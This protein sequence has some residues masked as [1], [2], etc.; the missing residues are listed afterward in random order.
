MSPTM[1]MVLSCIGVFIG[2]TGGYWQLHDNPGV[3]V[4]TPTF[5]IGFVMAGFVPLGSY[6]VGLISKAP[7]EGTTPPPPGGKP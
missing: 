5:W 4:T 3:L 6:F 1:R 2:G 7:W